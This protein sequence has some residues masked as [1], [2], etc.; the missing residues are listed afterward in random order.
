VVTTIHHYA[1]T[2][3]WRHAAEIWRW[4]GTYVLSRNEVRGTVFAVSEMQSLEQLVQQLY[5]H[6]NRIKNYMLLLTYLFF[7]Y[8]PPDSVGQY[9]GRLDARWPISFRR[10]K[11]KIFFYDF[12]WPSY[13]TFLVTLQHPLTVFE[14][15]TQNENKVRVKPKFHLASHVMSQH[16]TTR[17]TCR[18]CGDE[19]VELCCTTCSTQPKC[20]G[21]TRRKCH[22]MSRRDEPSQIWALWNTQHNTDAVLNCDS[23]CF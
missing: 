18:A 20:I 5:T 17:S 9:G 11:F 6:S 7:N 13:S 8:A 21:S 1:L 23:L 4:S 15:T 2:H 12:Q 3:D 10:Q 16:D 22:V 19:C 14:E